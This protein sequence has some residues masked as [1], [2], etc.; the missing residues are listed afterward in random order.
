MCRNFSLILVEKLDSSIAVQFV[1]Q[2][3]L[4]SSFDEGNPNGGGFYLFRNEIDDLYW[5]DH[6]HYANSSHSDWMRDILEKGFGHKIIAH[7]RKASPTTSKDDKKYN[8]PYVLSLFAGSQQGT[9]KL[10]EKPDVSQDTFIDTDTWQ[11]FYFLNK[12]ISSEEDLVKVDTYNEWIER[13]FYEGSVFSFQIM[14]KNYSIFMKGD[15]TK[16]LAYAPI[17]IKDSFIG[18]MVHTNYLFFDLVPKHFGHLGISVG[19]Y[20]SI[21]NKRGVIIDN[22]GNITDLSL[23]YTLKRKAFS[24]SKKV[25]SVAEEGG[26]SLAND[27]LAAR[28]NQIRKS[29]RQNMQIR[30]NLINVWMMYWAGYVTSIGVPLD[31]FPP[32]SSNDVTLLE[33]MVHHVLG[34]FKTPMNTKMINMWNTHVTSSNNSEVLYYTIIFR[35]YAFWFVNTEVD[36]I[37][38]EHILLQLIDYIKL[39]PSF[40]ENK[41]IG[42]TLSSG[43]LKAD[44]ICLVDI[45]DM[46]IEQFKDFI[47]PCKFQVKLSKRS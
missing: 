34:N 47:F 18:Y 11:A 8:H 3:M 10:E 7:V 26:L 39:A 1:H 22:E 31:N 14:S 43:E 45:D 37:F 33:K 42:Y 17:Y 38:N 41:V 19:D 46:N 36:H 32:L 24:Y 9:L 25:S 44:K 20:I 15:D 12:M 28:I 5:R 6:N 2:I 16:N 29:L 40:D 23:K 27:S 13:Y 21:E 30:Q 4:L 35:G